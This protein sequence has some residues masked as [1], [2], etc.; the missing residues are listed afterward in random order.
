MDIATELYWAVAI[1][2]FGSSTV[3]VFKKK[4]ASGLT[5]D[6]VVGFFEKKSNEIWVIGPAGFNVPIDTTHKT[7]S[8]ILT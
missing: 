2:V 8:S 5:T 1:S 6:I 7:L 3:V 4:E